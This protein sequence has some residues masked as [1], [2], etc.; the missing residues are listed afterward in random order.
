MERSTPVRKPHT[1]TADLLTWSETPLPDP[2][3]GN[4]GTPASR[5]AARSHQV[6]FSFCLLGL[7]FLFGWLSRTS[8]DSHGVFRLLV[9]FFSFIQPSGGVGA[10]LFGGQVTPEEAESLLKRSDLGISSPFLHRTFV[11]SHFLCCPVFDLVIFE[12]SWRS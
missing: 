4:A 9:L 10:V 1:S 5:S 8:C 6:C 11:F 3:A 2:A 12:L 7:P